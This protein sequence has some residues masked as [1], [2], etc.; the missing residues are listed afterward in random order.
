MRPN[1]R[2]DKPPHSDR[3]G[4]P[5]TCRRIEHFLPEG[6]WGGLGVAVSSS[7][8][9]IGSRGAGFEGSIEIGNGPGSAPRVARAVLRARPRCRGGC[10]RDWV[11]GAG[12]IGAVLHIRPGP[13]VGGSAELC[14]N[15]LTINAG[16]IL[17]CAER[18]PLH[19]G[20]RQQEDDDLREPRNR[21]EN[22]E[23]DRGVP[24]LPCA[25]NLRNRPGEDPAR[26]RVALI[27]NPPPARTPQGAAPT[28]PIPASA[29]SPTV[30]KVNNSKGERRRRFSPS[31]L[32]V[33][34]IEQLERIGDVGD[35]DLHTDACGSLLEAGGLAHGMSIGA[36]TPTPRPPGVG[37]HPG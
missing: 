27:G 10:H 26:L 1:H 6:F 21:A 36:P 7:W 25:N 35:V 12:L 11:C 20:E 17:P 5:R 9:S 3:Q 33:V 29:P 4:A 31:G 8:S 34:R 16:E 19:M 15:A 18:V 22:P 13:A 32:G 14:G 23:S 2:R 24:S 37:G 30:R 28:A